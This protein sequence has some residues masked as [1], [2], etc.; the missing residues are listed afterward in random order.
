MSTPN[1]LADID[2]IGAVRCDACGH[3]WNAAG[4]ASR[5]DRLECPKCGAFAGRGADADPQPEVRP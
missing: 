5:T 4:A 1:P 2:W 3:E